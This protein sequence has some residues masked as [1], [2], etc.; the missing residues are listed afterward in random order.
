MQPPLTVPHNLHLR[1]V[2]TLLLFSLFSLFSLSCS[3]SWNGL[4]VYACVGLGRCFGGYCNS[5]YQPRSKL[6]HATVHWFF[7]GG[8]RPHKMNLSLLDEWC[9]RRH[10]PIQYDYNTKRQ[11]FTHHR[12]LFIILGTV[13]CLLCALPESN[14]TQA[15]YSK[16]CCRPV[17]SVP[18]LIH[19][20]MPPGR[21]ER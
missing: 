14:E 3:V 9:L 15:S 20:S 12:S 6:H 8:E 18:P 11:I 16:Y 13:T 1:S 2:C 19:R 21:H 4:D 10:L 17:F 7:G 5:H